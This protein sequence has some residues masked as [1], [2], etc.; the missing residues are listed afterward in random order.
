MQPLAIDG[1]AMWS[2]WQ[3]ERKMFFNSFFLQ[4][5]DGNIAVDPLA[6][7]EE[8]LAYLREHGGVA[9]VVITNRDH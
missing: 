2:A 9:W 7:S 8:D 4:R 5:P 6:P 3:P 1:A